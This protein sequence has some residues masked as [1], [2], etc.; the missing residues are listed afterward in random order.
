MPFHRSCKAYYFFYY[1]PVGYA[2]FPNYTAL[3]ECTFPNSSQMLS[4]FLMYS[5]H[6]TDY[7]SLRLCENFL[8]EMLL[9]QN[10]KSSTLQQVFQNI[11]DSRNECLHAVSVHP[12]FQPLVAFQIRHWLFKEQITLVGFSRHWMSRLTFLKVFRLS[13]SLSDLKL[14]G[15]FTSKIIFHSNILR[16]SRA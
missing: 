16:R 8:P 2:N 6:F 3:S 9:V 10:N 7:S 14:M 12:M 5:V 4:C 11:V 15:V 13:T 1:F